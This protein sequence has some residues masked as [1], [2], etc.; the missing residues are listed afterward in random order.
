[1]VRSNLNSRVFVDFIAFSPFRLSGFAGV[2]ARYRGGKRN[3]L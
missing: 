3:F 2:I 1:M